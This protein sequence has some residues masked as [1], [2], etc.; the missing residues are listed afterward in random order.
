MY[1]N[2]FMFVVMKNILP[3]KVIVNERY[4]IKGSWV[5]RSATQGS[6]G[7]RATCRHCS[8]YF[9]LGSSENCS[10]VI[11]GHEPLVTLKDNDMINKV[12]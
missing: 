10:E 3:P 9:T 6:P 5:N 11:G 12:N 8:E 1:G 4:D 7:S 2:E